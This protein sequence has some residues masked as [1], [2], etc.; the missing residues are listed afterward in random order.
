[1]SPTSSVSIKQLI[2]VPSLITL[3][4]TILRLVGELQHWPTLLFNPA[5]GGG[6]AI[7]GI[8]WLPFIFGIYFAL[9]LADAGERP[10]SL[11]KALGFTIL[12]LLAMVGGGALFAMSK[13]SS[14]GM[15]VGAVVLLIAASLIPLAGWGPLAKTL[16][17][18][19]YAARI[20]AAIIM[21]FAIRGSWG[22]HYD[23]PPPGFPEM[24]WLPKYFLIGFIP[25][26]T[27]WIAF[28]VIVGSLFGIA[29]TAIMRRKA[30]AQATT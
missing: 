26:L 20:P 18:Y 27:I 12:G 2:L 28:T 4:V 30:P 16:L 8:S 15:I 10:A 5:A 24:S 23:G 29:A 13:F 17:A 25:Q 21:I 14:T 11:G 1:M 9:K 22:T 7:V 3:G 19:A 6:G